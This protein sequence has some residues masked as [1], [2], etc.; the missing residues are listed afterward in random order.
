M[1]TPAN[2]EKA[3]HQPT[4]LIP[5]W[6]GAELPAP[7]AQ[8]PGAAAGHHEGPELGSTQGQWAGMGKCTYGEWGTKGTTPP[9]SGDGS[10]H[11]HAAQR[12]L[13]I[14]GGE[15]EVLQLHLSKQQE[16]HSA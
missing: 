2:E 12:L 8:S 7:T 5:P 16:I 3:C 10:C 1:F 11:S 15:A 13:A 6:W 14:A 9:A 4:A